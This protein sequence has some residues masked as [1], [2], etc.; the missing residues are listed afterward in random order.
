MRIVVQR[1]K[2][3]SVTVDGNCVGAIEKG[4]LLLLGVHTTDTTKE[5]D[6]LVDKCID[7]RIFPDGEDKMNLSLADIDGEVLVVSQ[8]TL[9]GNCAKGRRP[10][11]IEAAPAEKGNELYSYFVSKIRSRCRKVATGIFG[12][13]MDV[14]LLNDGPVTLI[15]EKV[16]E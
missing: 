4:L 8:F 3:A 5:A 15:L 1:V 13:M 14:E 12:A 9:Y 11:F 16:A 7:L 6:F 2:H 10:S